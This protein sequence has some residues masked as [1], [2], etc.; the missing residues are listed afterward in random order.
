MHVNVCAG[1]GGRGRLLWSCSDPEENHC[2]LQVS[3]W[4]PLTPSKSLL[5]LSSC[6]RMLDLSGWKISQELTDLLA[7]GVAGECSEKVC[8]SAGGRGAGS[9]TG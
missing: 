8:E 3:W 2:L 6:L 5:S 4:M 1:G 7:Q 9:V